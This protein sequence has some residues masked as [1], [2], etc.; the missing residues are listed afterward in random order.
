[1]QNPESLRP[2][3]AERTLI[4]IAEDDVIVQNIA[5]MALESAGYFILTADN[6]EDALFLSRKYLGPIHLL[7]SD[8]RMPKMDGITLGSKS[9]SNGHRPNC[10]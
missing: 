6:G 8:V 10:S 3:C 7:L 5:R 4:L 1:M 9:R 2:D